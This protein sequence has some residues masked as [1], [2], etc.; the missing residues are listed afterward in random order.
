MRLKIFTITAGCSGLVIS[1]LLFLFSITAPAR[2]TTFPEALL[3]EL[4][5]KSASIPT[6]PS[7]QSRQEVFNFLTKK[8]VFSTLLYPETEQKAMRMLKANGRSFYQQLCS[9]Q[10]GRKAQ[11]LYPLSD[12]RGRPTKIL[13]LL[14][15]LLL[16]TRD[17]SLEFKNNLEKELIQAPEKEW[18]AF[19]KSALSLLYLSKRFSLEDLGL[20]IRLSN[21]SDSLATFA[22]FLQKMPD[23]SANLLTIA[24]HLTPDTVPSFFNYLARWQKTGISA[25]LKAQKLSPEAFMFLLEHQRGIGADWPAFISN[26]YDPIRWFDT[27]HAASPNYAFCLKTLLLFVSIFLFLFSCTILTVRLQFSYYLLFMSVGVLST[28]ILSLVFERGPL[29]QPDL[30]VLM[31]SNAVSDNL[32]NSPPSTKGATG[33]NLISLAFTIFFFFLQLFLYFLG[34]NHIHK[35]KKVDVDA[36]TKLKLLENEDH[37]FDMGLYV[38]LSGTVLSL[39]VITMGWTNIG[40][41]SAYT[42][43]LFGIVEVALLKLIS[44]RPYKKVLILEIC[45]LEKVQENE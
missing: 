21:T 25:L 9:W 11:L 2:I 20:C 32:F 15:S 4:K 12:S 8:P 44:L 33:M 13:F 16:E 31:L 39:I 40:L 5:P 41:M 35:I 37:L 6:L 3:S 28:L 36:S 34:R 38:G 18:G 27:L 30:P 43:T 22:A 42:S 24:K 17:I 26:D 29:M 45:A 14:F 7:F 23:E 19:E 1:I 10:E